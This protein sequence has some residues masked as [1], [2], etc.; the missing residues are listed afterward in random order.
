[1]RIEYVLDDLGKDFSSHCE[2]EIN[3]DEFKNIAKVKLN[4]D[5]IFEELNENFN[6]LKNNMISVINDLKKNINDYESI[7]IVD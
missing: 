5:D 4:S 7:K 3:I 1:M 6:L 2:E